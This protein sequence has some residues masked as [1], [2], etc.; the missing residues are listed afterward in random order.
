MQLHTTRREP[1]TK[2]EIIRTH[3]RQN[4]PK[5]YGLDWKEAHTEND[6]IDILRYIDFVEGFWLNA[7]GKDPTNY[8][9]ARN[10][11]LH[12]MMEDDQNINRRLDLVSKRARSEAKR[13][14]QDR[15]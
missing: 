10:A 9:I 7:R 11:L 3:Y 4:D 5:L 15:L 14:R 6:W 8:R 1:V 12:L 2:E 13:Q